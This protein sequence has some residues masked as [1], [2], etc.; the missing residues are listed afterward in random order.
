MRY[1]IPLILML[2]L[3]FS[4]SGC[5]TTL[6]T[7]QYGEPISP[8]WYSNL[9]TSPSVLAVIPFEGYDDASQSLASRIESQLRSKIISWGEYKIVERGKLEKLLQEQRLSL[10]GLT[11]EQV[12]EVG[13]MVGTNIILTGTV[14]DL[15]QDESYLRHLNQPSYEADQ[16]ERVYSFSL[17]LRVISVESGEIL[18]EEEKNFSS[19]TDGYMNVKRRSEEE[20]KKKRE[21]AVQAGTGFAVIQ[22]VAEIAGEISALKKMQPFPTLKEKCLNDAITHFFTKLVSYQNTY[23]VD[24]TIDK[25]GNKHFKNKS[26]IGH[27]PVNINNKTS[28]PN[29]SDIDSSA[30]YSD[31]SYSYKTPSK[32]FQ[33]TMLVITLSS[34]AVCLTGAILGELNYSEYI[35]AQDANDAIQ[36]RNNYEKWDIIRNYSGGVAIGSGIIWFVSFKF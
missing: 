36:L 27:V 6:T 13:K 22:G 11:E 19:K 31:K 34:A 14:T 12:V 9:P 29:F 7:T 5:A 24:F 33:K 30:Y 18:W 3:L 4:L 16:Y 28:T 8:L 25:Y 10:S 35:R 1:K 21:E 15:V 23:K 2:F 32:S 20:M 17:N 26:F